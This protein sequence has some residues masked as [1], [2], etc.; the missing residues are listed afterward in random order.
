MKTKSEAKHTPKYGF[1][2]IAWSE[3][4]ALGLRY[5]VR[6]LDPLS[7]VINGGSTTLTYCCTKEQALLIVEAVNS[8]EALNSENEAL[9]A[10]IVART[11]ELHEKE[12]IRERLDF[13]LAALLE[14]AKR[15][16]KAYLRL[17]IGPD[18]EAIV[19]EEM[20][21]LENAIALAEGKAVQ[22]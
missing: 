7:G 3:G 22:S 16:V 4:L 9:K 8:H 10:E 13:D 15:A 21:D 14:A 17:P 20:E 11:K 6:T 18:V 2:V 19:M 1:E 5:A 12:A